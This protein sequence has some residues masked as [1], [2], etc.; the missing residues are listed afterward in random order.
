MNFEEILTIIACILAFIIMI[1]SLIYLFLSRKKEEVDDDELPS[2]KETTKKDTKKEVRKIYTKVPVTEFMQFDDIED[3]M[4]KQYKGQRYLMVIKCEGINYD[5]M[6]ATEKTSVEYGFTQFLNTLRSPIQLYIQTRTV[7]IEE[8]ISIYSKKVEEIRQN[9]ILKQN[10]YNRAIENNASSKKIKELRIDIARLQ[11]LYDYGYDVLNETEKMSLN[12]N[13]LKKNYYIVVPYTTEAIDNGKLGVEE[14]QNMVFS[15]LYTNCQTMIRTLS[16]I[17]IRGKV[18]DSN[19]LAELLYVA[20]NRD[21]SDIYSVETAIKAGYTELYSIAPD[22]LDK[23]MKILDDMIEKK[24]VDKAREYIE[25]ARTEKEIMVEDKE[26]NM[27]E[28]INELAKALLMENSDSIGEDIA[29]IAISKID[30][31]KEA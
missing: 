13:I 29:E 2:N 26:K 27:D 8:N 6:S 23:K 16:A 22:V 9:L 11:N 28:L 20:Y 4:I 31:S 5:L 3:N 10:E 17:G 15:E 30:N 21:E 7:N 12:K 25:K 19:E 18:L 1:L 24:A 14:R